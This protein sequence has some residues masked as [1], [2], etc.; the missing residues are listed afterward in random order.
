MRLFAALLFPWM[1]LAVQTAAQSQGEKAALYRDADAY[2]VYSAALSTYRLSANRKP[3]MFVIRSETVNSFG[4]YTNTTGG[5]GT[6]LRPDLEWKD[7]V[8]PA[9]VDF[10]EVN[11]S[12]WRLA[13]KFNSDIPYRLM[14]PN[15]FPAANNE[16]AWADFYKK[17]P[18]SG[19]FIDLSAVGF[20]PDKTIAIFSLSHWCGMLCGEGSYRTFRK[21]DDKWAPLKWKGQTCNWVS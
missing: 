14:G 1:W 3:G 10:L 2:E 15:D 4:S 17:Y 7:I 16:K 21:V 8:G 13:E 20:N 12:K 5:A 19:G 18:E 9:I 11:K 6:C